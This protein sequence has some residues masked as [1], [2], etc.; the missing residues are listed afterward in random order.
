MKNKRLIFILPLIIGI[1]FM[2]SACDK[3]ESENNL[4][5]YAFFKAD[6]T[7]VISG[8]TVYF[9]DYS[10]GYPT[11]WEWTFEG[12]TPTT[13]TE[14]NPKV[15]YD[16]PGQYKVTLRVTNKGETSS[17]TQ[18]EYIT[19]VSTDTLEDDLL[20]FFPFDGSL[21]DNGPDQVEAV[22]QGNVTFDGVDRNGQANSVAVFDG[23]SIIIIPDN[24][25]FNFHSNDFSISCWLKT[26]HTEKM[27]IWQESGAGG[28]RDNQAWLRIGDNSSDRVIRFDTEDGGGGNII[29]YG[30]GPATAVSDGEWHHIVCVREGGTTR[31][32][33]DGEMKEEMIKGTPKDVS[34]AGDFKIGGQEGPAGDYHTYFTG[35]IDDL[36]VYN[37]ALSD[38]E[39]AALYLK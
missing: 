21:K 13:S 26:T 14:Q 17:K 38:E 24:E 10:I 1:F 5:L 8:D 16:K 15:I 27:M 29:N 35:L 9:E 37:K 4:F 18:E 32:Y 33:V 2:F 22:N 6:E 12:A 7:K 3:N 25:T 31:L 11:S 23:S 19:V 28:S 36:S 30:D 20:A 34:N 39:V